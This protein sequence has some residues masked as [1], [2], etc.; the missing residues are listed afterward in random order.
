VQVK[1]RVSKFSVQSHL[2]ETSDLIWMRQAIEQAILAAQHNEVPIG[3]VIVLDG[4]VLAASHNSPIVNNDACAH[5]EILAIQQACRLLGNYRLGSMATLYVTLQP[6]LMC[7]GAIFH[8]RIGRV[9]IGCEQSR[10]HSN[11]S[12]TLALFE[13][14]PSWHSCRFETACLETECAQVLSSFFKKRRKQ[15]EQVIKELDNLLH[16][17]NVNKETLIELAQMGYH[18]PDDFLQCGLERVANE[19]RLRSIELKHTHALQQA[20]IFSSL[21]DYF[22]GEPVRSWKHY[23]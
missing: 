22:N 19:L 18:T 5:A 12:E 1:N 13:Q 14:S 6:C 7:L 8:S 16:L 10:Y 4:Q 21:Y 3:A 20:A 23:L 15:R 9:V 11:L 17:P 2:G